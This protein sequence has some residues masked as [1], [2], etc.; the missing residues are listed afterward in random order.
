[1]TIW[2]DLSVPLIAP[3]VR[4][5]GEKQNE[6]KLGMITRSQHKAILDDSGDDKWSIYREL[7]ILG[8]GLS[9]KELDKL[10]GPD[11]NSLCQ[12]ADLAYGQGSEYWFDRLVWGG[13]SKAKQK[14]AQEEY[15]A[16]DKLPLLIPLDTVVHGHI[17]TIPLTLPT[18]GV[19]NAMYQLDEDKQETFI[20][21]HVSGL[22]AD[23]LGE[24]SV[25]D[26]KSLQLKVSDF[27]SK[28]GDHF[29]ARKISKS[30]PT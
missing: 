15:Q 24:L 13:L 17:D 25:P 8:A 16:V 23:E 11:F 14:A 22:S 29:S 19:M 21:Q 10:T 27:L 26:G 3:L 1:M 30:S 5:N 20:T 7:I 2:Q 18:V 28:T 6:L 12:Q 4:D 9:D